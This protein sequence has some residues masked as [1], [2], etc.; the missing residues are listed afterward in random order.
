[1]FSGEGRPPTSDFSPG[2]LA[3]KLRFN[4]ENLDEPKMPRFDWKESQL[5]KLSL[6]PPRFSKSNLSMHQDQIKAKKN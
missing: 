2:D 5:V 4:E 6:L 3:L 1:M